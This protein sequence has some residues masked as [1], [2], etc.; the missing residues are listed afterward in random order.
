MVIT[1][2]TYVEKAEQTILAHK[3]RKNERTGKPMPMVTTTKIR[4]LLTMATDI[5]NEVL[6]CQVDSL[7]DEICGRIQ[8]LKVRFIYEAGR[9]PSVKDFI[10]KADILKCV[11]EIK[12]NKKQY[13]LFHKYME[14]L[15]AYHRFYGGKDN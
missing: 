7:S 15:V 8:Y 3:N 6:N 13:L 11:D 2:T 9:E 4:N 12:D 1:E 10:I 14:A 5:Y